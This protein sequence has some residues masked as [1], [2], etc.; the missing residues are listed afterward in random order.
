MPSDWL[1][2]GHTVRL[3][4][5]LL[6]KLGLDRGLAEP[7]GDIRSAVGDDWL[8]VFPWN[9][10]TNDVLIRPMAANGF[11]ISGRLSRRCDRT[12]AQDSSC[13]WIGYYM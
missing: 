3:L 10:F 13:T 7:G 2:F 9:T 6:I 4:I 12:L 5:R 8:L 1:C 11:C